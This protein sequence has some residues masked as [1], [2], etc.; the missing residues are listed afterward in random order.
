RRLDWMLSTSMMLVELGTKEENTE[1]NRVHQ[2]IR[3]FDRDT[4]YLVTSLAEWTNPFL[5]QEILFKK[6][7]S[8]TFKSLLRN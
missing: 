8:R 6:F 5:S 4:L 1:N 3:N 2:F 7:G